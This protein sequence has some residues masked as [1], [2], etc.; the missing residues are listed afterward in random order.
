MP[1]GSL[2]EERTRAVWEPVT[3]T[4]VPPG[5]CCFELP[6]SVLEEVH[7][8]VC[9]CVHCSTWQTCILRGSVHGMFV[10]CRHRTSVQYSFIAAATPCHFAWLSLI[11]SVLTLCHDLENLT[12]NWDR[13]SPMVIQSF[14]YENSLGWVCVVLLQCCRDVIRNCVVIVAVC[15]VVVRS[16]VF[17]MHYPGVKRHLLSR[18]FNY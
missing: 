1:L 8:V 3:M 12:W 15:S 9:G 7:R 13:V 14:W 10:S 11:E 17:M 16:M 6:T 4:A 2:L 5:W 18:M